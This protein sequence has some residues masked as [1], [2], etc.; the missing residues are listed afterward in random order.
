MK[1]ILLLC[2]AGMLF[3]ASC[4]EAPEAG[5]IIAKYDGEVI[6]EGSQ[7][8]RILGDLHQ[9]E[10]GAWQIASDGNSAI[11][12]QSQRIKV[13]GAADD[14]ESIMA[15]LERDRPPN[16]QLSDDTLR[17]MKEISDAYAYAQLA[18]YESQ[19]INAAKT[20]LENTSGKQLSSIEGTFVEIYLQ[21]LA[22]RN[23]ASIMTTG[24]PLSKADYLE[25]IQEKGLEN[26]LPLEINRIYN[27]LGSIEEFS[28]AVADGKTINEIYFRNR[29][30][31]A[32]MPQD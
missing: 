25:F 20:K 15:Q 30:L 32:C 28:Q 3:V 13:A 8:E 22:C 16:V 4:G 7:I 27:A 29:F 11:A 6:R 24:M 17:K 14:I 18:G 9:Y 26:I 10:D 31:K 19:A 12:I 5:V 1:G 23:V 21:E 2:L